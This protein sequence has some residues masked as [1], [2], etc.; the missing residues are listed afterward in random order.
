VPSVF[1]VD[2][3]F[4]EAGATALRPDDHGL[5]GDGAFEAIKVRGGKPFAL[6]RHLARLERSA[7][8]LG[9]T[10][11]LDV[12]RTGIDAIVQDD[13]A[14]GGNCW[15]RVT[16]TGGSAPMGTGGV[17]TV[18]TV[19]IALAPM[20]AWGPTCD[21]AISPWS[22]NP[23]SPSAGLKTISYADNVIALR[24]AHEQGADE[25]LFTNIADVLC[26]GTGT[27]VFVAVGDR[28]LTPPLSGGCLAGVTRDLLLEHGDVA[29]EGDI[30]PD[31]L[32]GATEAFLTSTSRDV[33]PIAT[34][35]RAPLASAPGPLT[36]IA[37]DAFAR[38]AQDDDP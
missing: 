14:R 1:W 3:A 5:V 25:A 13:L 4:V 22:R 34:V 10:P 24:W 23:G 18:P 33:H 38:I 16:V 2:G 28:L 26:E 36:T 6:T 17:G 11:D 21:V 15:L 7:G 29:E 9:I 12:I 27:N 19:V 31:Q 8:A 20:A 30:T 37:R 32:R 35:D